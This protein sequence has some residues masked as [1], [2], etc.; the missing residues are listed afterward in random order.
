MEL[1]LFCWGIEDLIVM[2]PGWFF[3]MRLGFHSVLRVSAVRAVSTLEVTVVSGRGEECR[4]ERKDTGLVLALELAAADSTGEEAMLVG[5]LMAGVWWETVRLSWTL[6]LLPE[7][8]MSLNPST[9]RSALGEEERVELPPVEVRHL[10]NASWR[11]STSSSLEGGE[12]SVLL[13][14]MSVSWEEDV[15]GWGGY[16][17]LY[18]E[19]LLLLLM[20]LLLLK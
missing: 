3:V 9:K 1:L 18:M 7:V 20:L 8:V 14:R 13:E 10:K 12:L 11:G 19:L 2:T 15:E 5:L 16:E 4:E 17:L 6:R